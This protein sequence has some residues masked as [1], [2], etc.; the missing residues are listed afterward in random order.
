MCLCIRKCKNEVIFYGRQWSLSTTLAFIIKK[1]F[2]KLKTSS[3]AT[4]LQNSNFETKQKLFMAI[5]KV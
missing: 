4:C 3:Y 1:I 2:C 5:K